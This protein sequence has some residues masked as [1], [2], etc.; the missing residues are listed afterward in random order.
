VDGEV[1]VAGRVLCWVEFW[2]GVCV[3]TCVEAC[4]ETV[5]SVVVE[6]TF[7]DGVRRYEVPIK[8]MATAN[9]I[10]AA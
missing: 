10:A 8:M 5:V 3:E 1:L 2:G 9:T 4:E 7:A 6:T